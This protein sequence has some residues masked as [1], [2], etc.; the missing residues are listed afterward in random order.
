MRNPWNQGI[1]QVD[2][3]YRPGDGEKELKIRC[4]SCSKSDKSHDMFLFMKD[5]ESWGSIPHWENTFR[6]QAKIS[7]F[8]RRVGEAGTWVFTF[9]TAD[10]E[11][12]VVV[13]NEDCKKILQWFIDAWGEVYADGKMQVVVSRMGMD[14][15]MGERLRASPVSQDTPLSTSSNHLKYEVKKD[16]NVEVFIRNLSNDTTGFTPVWFEDGQTEKLKPVSLRPGEEKNL[17]EL[18]IDRDC[19]VHLMDSGTRLLKLE[20][21]TRA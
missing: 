1:Y 18:E 12:K 20:F 8:R 5:G 16:S 17:I 6:D 10:T 14:G 13:T 15:A 11:R 19:Q 3:P 4:T 21:V 2:L 7:N 9:A